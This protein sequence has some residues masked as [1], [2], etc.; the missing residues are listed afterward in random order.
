MLRHWDR[1][2]SVPLQRPPM[3]SLCSQFRSRAN[4]PRVP[5]RFDKPARALHALQS[6]RVLLRSVTT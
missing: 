2:V 3:I 6:G 1:E 4:W 5:S